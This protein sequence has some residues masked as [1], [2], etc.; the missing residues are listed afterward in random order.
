MTISGY[1]Y[2]DVNP[3]FKLLLHCYVPYNVFPKPTK[4]RDTHLRAATSKSV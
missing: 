2:Y 3:L 4:L 1:T